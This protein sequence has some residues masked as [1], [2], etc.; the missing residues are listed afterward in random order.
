MACRDVC[1]VLERSL[2]L[3]LVIND[4]FKQLDVNDILL[5]NLNKNWR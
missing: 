3:A 5:M 1:D 4:A 2:E